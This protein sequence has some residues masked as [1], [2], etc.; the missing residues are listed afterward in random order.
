MAIEF[1]YDGPRPL[2]DLGGNAAVRFNT[3]PECPELSPGFTASVLGW[4]S[5]LVAS[6]SD[7][8]ELARYVA[9]RF[10]GKVRIL[11]N[12]AYNPLGWAEASW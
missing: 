5:E 3:V 9:E 7:L 10:G 12:S 1:K 8:G 6:G 4:G 11:H 2:R